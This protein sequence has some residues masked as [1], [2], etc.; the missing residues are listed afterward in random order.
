MNA[1]MTEAARQIPQ[2]MG[3]MMSHPMATGTMLAAGGYAAGKARWAPVRA[4]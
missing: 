4:R 3:S 2:A 1:P